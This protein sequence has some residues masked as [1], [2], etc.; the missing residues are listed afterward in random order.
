MESSLSSHSSCVS[1][2][3]KGVFRILDARVVDDVLYAV[4]QDLKHE[5]EAEDNAV[6]VT[7]LSAPSGWR[8][9]GQSVVTQSFLEILLEAH[10][11]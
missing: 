6:R 9:A 5:A 2:Y 4:T 7:H 8:C 3:S 1:E 11:T 10:Q